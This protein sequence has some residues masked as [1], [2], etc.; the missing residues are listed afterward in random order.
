MDLVYRW[1]KSSFSGGTGQCV[2]VTPRAVR[3]SKNP[4]GPTLRADLPQ[5]VRYAKSR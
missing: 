5:L 2:E 1:R 4:E 3:D